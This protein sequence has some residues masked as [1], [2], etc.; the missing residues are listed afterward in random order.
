MSEPESE[1]FDGEEEPGLAGF[2]YFTSHSY[3]YV[4]LHLKS[5]T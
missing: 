2:V 4:T 1:E 5:Q 3:Y